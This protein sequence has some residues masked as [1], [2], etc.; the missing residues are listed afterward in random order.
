[1]NTADAQD[2]LG[3]SNNS[4]KDESLIPAGGLTDVDRKVLFRC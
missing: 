1:M 4:A 2:I 3:L